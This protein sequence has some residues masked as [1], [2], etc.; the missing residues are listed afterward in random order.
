MGNGMAPVVKD[1]SYGQQA[2]FSTIV[3]TTRQFLLLYCFDFWVYFPVAFCCLPLLPEIVNSVHPTDRWR[4][5][6]F[7]RRIDFDSTMPRCGLTS[8]TA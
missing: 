3:S 2:D 7:D 6:Y 5:R 1:Q 8:Q 4:K